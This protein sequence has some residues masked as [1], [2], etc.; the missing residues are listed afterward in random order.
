[1]GNLIA[2]FGIELIKFYG[3][4]KII[5]FYVYDELKWNYY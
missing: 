2:A 3:L 1:M 5:K 4:R